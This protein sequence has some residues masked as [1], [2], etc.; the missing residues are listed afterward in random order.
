MGAIIYLFDDDPDY[1]ELV[2][3]AL[4]ARGI[5]VRS[6]HSLDLD[7]ALCQKERP[8]AFLIDLRIGRMGHDPWDYNGVC[9]CSE[10]RRKLDRFIPIIVLTGNTNEYLIATCLENGADDYLSKDVSFEAL[11]R[12]VSDWTRSNLSD[13]AASRTRLELVPKLKQAIEDGGLDTVL[14][15]RSRLQA[16]NPLTE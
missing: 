15:W 16:D 5:E 2:E 11:A 12:T 14:E 10:L 8:S 13:G 6:F 1:C 7:L 3:I 4:R 9:F